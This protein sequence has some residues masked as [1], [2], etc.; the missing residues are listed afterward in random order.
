MAVKRPISPDR[1]VKK[2]IEALEDRKALDIH[3]LDVRGRSGFTDFMVF[4]CGS[5]DRHL[6]ALADSV[7]EKAKESGV[8]PLGVEGENGGEWVLVDL[9]DAVVHIMLPQTRAFYQIEKLWE[10][11]APPAPRRRTRKTA[12]GES[13]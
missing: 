5:S 13:S 7:V 4:A 3:V 2:V 6:K 10:S 12:T 8:R 11:D 1:L 9:A